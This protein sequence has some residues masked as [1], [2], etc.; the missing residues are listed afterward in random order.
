MYT[1][2]DVWNEFNSDENPMFWENYQVMSN[3][4][5]VLG[6]I[7]G[8][9]HDEWKRIYGDQEGRIRRALGINRDY[10]NDIRKS[11]KVKDAVKMKKE[12]C[13]GISE[14]SG[15]MC[16]IHIHHIDGV[17]NFPERAGNYDN[18]VAISV[19]EHKLFHKVY[20][21]KGATHKN[22]VEFKE[23]YMSGEFDG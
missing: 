18:L 22:W 9:G 5:E 3:G 14:L 8:Y 6:T 21:S 12:N 7:M 13:G 4:V 16:N 20:G 23:R 2:E 1:Q 11:K 17:Y 10:N 19:E 15:Y